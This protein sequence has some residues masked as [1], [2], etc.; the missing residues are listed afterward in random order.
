MGLGGME[1]QVVRGLRK[2]ED[3]RMRRIGYVGAGMMATPLSQLLPWG[4]CRNVHMLL[5]SK[6]LDI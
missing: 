6:T 1:G 4:A 3:R 2:T 5:K